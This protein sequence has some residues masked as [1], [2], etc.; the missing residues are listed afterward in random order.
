M[1][2]K[3][4]LK[5]HEKVIIGGAVISSG[6]K[7]IELLVEN[8]VPILRQKDIMLEE[9]ANTPARRIYFAL[10]LM[11]IDIDNRPAHI[12]SFFGLARDIL[13][14][15]PSTG[16]YIKQICDLVT[17]SQFYHALKT[18]N[19]LIDYEKELTAHVE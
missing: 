9:N 4:S 19:Q 13:D 7:H 6:N 18:A 11:Y 14:A 1:S 3:L 5:P 12:E 16:S 17:T 2:L 15:A 10:Q 8:I